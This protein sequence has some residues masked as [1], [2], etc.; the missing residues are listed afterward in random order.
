MC[1][2]YV[3]HDKA[4]SNCVMGA[5]L[6]PTRNICLRLYAVCIWLAKPLFDIAEKFR[7]IWFVKNTPLKIFEIYVLM[8]V[9]VKLSK[10]AFIAVLNVGQILHGHATDRKGG[11]HAPIQSQQHVYLP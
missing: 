1:Y 5:P 3:Y 9:T 7:D 4:V 6:P 2:I 11:H 10:R 8:W